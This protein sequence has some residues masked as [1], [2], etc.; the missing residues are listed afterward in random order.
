[1]WNVEQ[2]KNFRISVEIFSLD[3]RKKLEFFE[4]RSCP[5]NFFGHLKW[6]FHNT[7][8]NISLEV[9]KQN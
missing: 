8:Q 6:S 9:Q 4:K 7:S 2:T 3:V 1:M 5:Q